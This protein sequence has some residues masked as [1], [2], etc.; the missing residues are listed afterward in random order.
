MCCFMCLLFVSK[1][2]KHFVRSRVFCSYLVL[3]HLPQ[4]RAN[5]VVDYLE[6]IYKRGPPPPPT[7]SD[8]GRR[9]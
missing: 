1:N 4:E 3:D 8:A 6:E 7:A 9:K 5:I 2:K